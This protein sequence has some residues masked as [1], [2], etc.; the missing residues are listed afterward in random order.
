MGNILIGQSHST[1]VKTKTGREYL[2][3]GLPDKDKLLCRDLD[4]RDFALI[5]RDDVLDI[6]TKREEPPMVARVF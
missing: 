4:T 6:N 2:V 3:M 1:K 5:Q